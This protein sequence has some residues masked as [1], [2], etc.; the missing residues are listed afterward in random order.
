M[1][2]IGENVF[3]GSNSTLV[4]PVRID[5]DSYVAAGSVITHAV[6]SDA[7]AVGR[8]RQTNKP[9]WVSKKRKKS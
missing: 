1:T 7:L 4:A 8:S 3:V 5:A 6:P 9:G 2:E